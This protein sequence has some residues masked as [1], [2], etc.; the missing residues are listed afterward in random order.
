MSLLVI[1]S[2]EIKRRH[3]RGTKLSPTL[4]AIMV[5]DLLCEW[6]PRAKYV[7]DLTAIEIIPGNAPSL[8]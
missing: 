8:L 2:I 4:F 7:D 1:V 5:N 3:P 6:Y